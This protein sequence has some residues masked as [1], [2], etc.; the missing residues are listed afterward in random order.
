MV[1]DSLGLRGYATNGTTKVFEIATGSGIASFTGVANIDPSSVIPGGTITT[2]TLPGD[3]IVTGSIQTLQIAAGAITTNTLAAGAVSA[4][5]LSVSFGGANLLQNGQLS[6]FTGLGPETAP[7]AL[8]NL[9]TNPSAEAGTTSW[10]NVNLVAPLVTAGAT[11]AQEPS[12]AAVGLFSLRVTTPATTA[13]GGVLSIP[14]S[15][16]AGTTYSISFYLK[17]AAGGETL[18]AFFGSSGTN[19]ASLGITATTGWVRSSF[20]WTPSVTASDVVFAVRTNSAVARTFY[21]DAIQAV[22]GAS[23]PSYFDGSTSD[24]ASWDGTPHAS[25]SR[26][27]SIAG[28]P[29]VATARLVNL[30]TNPSFE[31]NVASWTTTAGFV[32]SGAT[33]ARVVT[34]ASKGTAS[35]G[36][37]TFALDVR[38]N[39]ASTGLTVYGGNISGSGGTSV[40]VT[41]GTTFQRVTGTF[42]ADGTAPQTL[43]VKVA[44]AI[45]RT[46]HIDAVTVTAGGIAPDYFDGSI[47]GSAWIGTAHAS[48]SV[49]ADSPGYWGHYDLGGTGSASW[50]KGAGG[51]NGENSWKINYS[52]TSVA[53]GFASAVTYPARPLTSY[54]LSFYWKGTGLP[55]VASGHSFDLDSTWLLQPTVSGSVWQRYAIRLKS[56]AGGTS[57][58]D[59]LFIYPP[60]GTGSAEI[61]DIQYE[62]GETLS[63]FAP[64]S[65]E[66]LPYSVGNTTLLPDSVTTDKI[67]AATIQ[68]GDIAASTITAGNI[69]VSQLSAITADMGTITAGTISVPATT[70]PRVVLDAAGFRQYAPDGTTVQ[71]N[72]PAAGTTATFAGQLS[73]AG[74][75]FAAA[76]TFLAANG[77]TWHAGTLTGTTAADLLVSH[78]TGQT[79]VQLRS[80]SLSGSVASFATLKAEAF[81]TSEVSLSVSSIS[82]SGGLNNNVS[83][84]VGGNTFMLA[85][86]AGNSSYLRFPPTIVRTHRVNYGVQTFTHNGT[87]SVMVTVTHGLGAAPQAAVATNSN[88]NTDCTYRCYS[89][90]STTFTCEVRVTPGPVGSDSFQWIAIG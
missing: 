32:T 17:G 26:L 42:T 53:K 84:L 67:L 6:Y 45:V 63:P 25:T 11:I 73:A 24:L 40:A 28:D 61:T 70:G 64:A 51:P 79:R 23:V 58:V 85:D 54:V 35:A 14:G 7:T 46:I 43:A 87:G 59:N 60:T 19:F 65:S 68:G 82:S 88:N 18:T 3:R 47:A 86:Q 21:I 52:G 12:Q 33:I 34:Q 77:L 4:Q 31:T 41:A 74:I 76:T 90:G 37:Y 9:I 29:G 66:L 48:M 62:E 16:V 78:F 72:I 27:T 36:T 83:V 55:T 57:G 69:Q 8:V 30:V 2:N 15:F 49:R 20:Q 5:K 80:K 56:T 39:T 81:D 71:V 75:D 13:T 50:F 89:F 38:C 44:S 22:T 1:I 10:T